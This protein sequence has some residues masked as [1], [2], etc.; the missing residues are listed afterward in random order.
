MGVATFLGLDMA[1]DL[2]TISTVL[3]I[4]FMGVIAWFIVRTF[5][6]MPRTKPQEISPKSK[7]SVTWD[8]VAGV[9]ETK[10]ELR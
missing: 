7:S 6:L 8:E 1:W 9:E 5:K 10:E 2:Y 4:V 3:M